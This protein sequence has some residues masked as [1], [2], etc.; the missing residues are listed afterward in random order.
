MFP[1]TVSSTHF[2][3]E[4]TLVLLTL[5]AS[6]VTCHITLVGHPVSCS[7]NLEVLG[8]SWFILLLISWLNLNGLEKYWC[9]AGASTRKQTEIS[10]S[11]CSSTTVTCPVWLSPA[12]FS[13][14]VSDYWQHISVV[15][16]VWCVDTFH[17][18]ETPLKTS[19]RSP[20]TKQAS[21]PRRQ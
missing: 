1:Q 21:E 7:N 17:C 5:I 11:S 16:W 20:L 4:L 2:I 18:T 13:Q 15:W 3:T 14:Q 19:A 12:V 6:D 8:I 9:R 10:E